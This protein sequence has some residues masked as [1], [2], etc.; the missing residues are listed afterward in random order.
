MVCRAPAPVAVLALA[1]MFIGCGSTDRGDQVSFRGPVVVITFSALG[2]DVASGSDSET[3]MAHLDRLRGDSSWSG[4]AV[5][6][7]NWTG[8]S[9]ASLFTGLPVALHGVSHPGPARLRREVRT[10]AEELHGLGFETRLFHSAQWI[11]QLGFARGFE[12]VR[13]L[14]RIRS[15]VRALEE[16]GSGPSLTWIQLTLPRVAYRDLGDAAQVAAV[17]EPVP[18][19]HR[20]LY[21]EGV[22]QADTYL[23]R[24]LEALRRS[25][26]WDRSLLLVTADHGDPFGSDGELLSDLGALSRER[27]EVPL[28]LRLPLEW[29]ERLAVEGSEVVAQSRV[30]ATVLE[31]SGGRAVPAAAPSLLHDVEAPALSEL[32]FGNGYHELSVVTRGSQLRW[33]CHFAPAHPD[34][35]RLRA[36]ALRSEGSDGLASLFEGWRSSFGRAPECSGGEEEIFVS[37]SIDSASPVDDAPVGKADLRAL[38]QQERVFPPPWSVEPAAPAPRM[39]ERDLR[40]LRAWGIPWAGA[41]QQ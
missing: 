10:L 13:P 33:R 19:V 18:E 7:A 12:V 41:P 30:F 31:L 29:R 24:L 15:A 5:A 8:A 40:S 6:S 16:L 20:G 39:L 27:L 22:Q 34:Y 9:L 25:G 2:A 26:Q 1:A 28:L 3:V 35:D 11:D 21:L 36:A 38:L 32:Y 23:A 37:W 17:P 14:R 4:R